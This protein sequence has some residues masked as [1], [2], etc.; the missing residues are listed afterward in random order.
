MNF[1]FLLL[2]LI[3][4]PSLFNFFSSD[5]WFLMRISQIGS[6]QQFLNFFSFNQTAESAAFYRPIPQQLFLFI[7]QKLFG[8]NPLPYHLFVLFCFGLVLYLLNLLA[9]KLDF[10]KTQTAIT[11]MVYGVASANF[12]QVYFLS[13]FQDI[14]LPLFVL[15][16]LILF[17][18]KKFSLSLV[19]F[20]LSLM[21]KETAVIMPLL[22]V[23]I[24][25][26]KKKQF[27]KL[28]I[29]YALIALVYLFLRLIVFGNTQGDSY[30]WD[31]SPYKAGNTFMWY[32]LWTI[33]TPEILVDYVGSGFKILPKLFTDMPTWS[34]VILIELVSSI[35]ALSVFFVS[36]R[37]QLFSKSRFLIFS[38][39]FFMI[40]LIPVIFIPWHKFTHAL[41]LPLLGFALLIGY[42]GK[43]LKW[44]LKTFLVVFIIT[45][46]STQ[47]LLFSKH[48]SVTRGTIAKRV[49]EYMNNNYPVYPSGKYFYFVNNSD[50]QKTVWGES[51][52]VGISLSMSDFFKVYYHDNSIKVYYEDLEESKPNK[53]QMIFIPSQQ[54]LID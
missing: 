46:L 24:C 22:L 45:N 29:P 36:V 21:S 2:P 34:R 25:W 8:L 28:V 7:F 12:P 47:V 33:G 52:Q 9:K 44:A 53:E 11:L 15:L 19:F 30:I 13:A 51:K 27:F 23:L 41:S 26:F 17:L 18:N 48:Y 50:N 4:L 49:Y 32:S 38:I 10:T 14:L 40:S 3:Y 20:V 54:F 31:F 1:L 39:L 37:R 42:F 35:L 5:D 43:D 16:S 6:F